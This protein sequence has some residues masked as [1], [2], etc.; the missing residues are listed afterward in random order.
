MELNIFS[1]KKQGILSIIALLIVVYLIPGIW[2][3]AK[4]DSSKKIT[5]VLCFIMILWSCSRII[6][7]DFFKDSK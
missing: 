4:D 6:F 5:Y 7:K 1:Q 3:D 2:E